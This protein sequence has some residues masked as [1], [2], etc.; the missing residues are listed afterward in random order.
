MWT[1]LMLIGNGSISGPSGRSVIASPQRP[2]AAVKI[3]C[4]ARILSPQINDN[5]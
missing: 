3:Y 2:E 5:A 4:I 1:A